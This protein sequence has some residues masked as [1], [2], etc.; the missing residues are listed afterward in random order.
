[1]EILALLPPMRT[2]CLLLLLGASGCFYDL[3]SAGKQCDDQHPCP[4]GLFCVPSDGELSECR[5]SLP[6]GG[7]P[8]RCQPVGGKRCL[9]ESGYDAVEE[10]M[11]DSGEWEETR[12]ADDQYCHQQTISC[13]DDCTL[14][15]NCDDALLT[16]NSCHPFTHR[17]TPMSLCADDLDCSDS[18]CAQGACVTLPDKAAT[19]RV[20][21]LDL[22][23]FKKSPD[24]DDGSS[25]ECNLSGNIVVLIT[26]AS[27]KQASGTAGLDV[28]IFRLDE[29]LIGNPQPIQTTT[30]AVIDGKDQYQLLNVP[31]RTELVLAISGESYAP[32]Y[33][34]GVYLRADACDDA[35]GSLLWE[36]P[37]LKQTL[38]RP[39]NSL[40]VDEEKGLL[41]ARLFDC[42]NS[43]RIIGGTVGSSLESQIDYYISV[44]DDSALV[45]DPTAT[46]T[47]T[48]GFFGAGNVDPLRG[49]ISARALE[50]ETGLVSLGSHWVRIFPES[51]SVV[52]FQKP[53]IPAD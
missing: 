28:K 40:P 51:V 11:A 14:D 15:T 33:L 3:S 27:S 21:E 53:L 35:S 18:N 49:I 34:F 47:A 20:G 26:S 10:C 2:L 13:L 16:E 12:C 32:L 39:Y 30:V 50:S 41:M 1:M 23:C 29:I 46:T 17:C 4:A 9:F 43:Q 48:P 25:T 44:N 36:L 6:D 8:S 24:A 37:V 38:Y 45:P 42:S 31:T 7:D 5:P 52:F 22:S 19:A